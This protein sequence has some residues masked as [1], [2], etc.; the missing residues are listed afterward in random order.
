LLCLENCWPAQVRRQP[1]A[2][3]LPAFCSVSR[4]NARL[5]SINLGSRGWRRFLCSARWRTASWFQKIATA[6]KHALTIADSIQEPDPWNSRPPS[7]A[8]R[9]GFGA[10]FQGDSNRAIYFSEHV[11]AGLLY[12]MSAAAPAGQL[13]NPTSAQVESGASS[14]Q[15]QVVHLIGLPDDGSRAA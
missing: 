4:L 1:S 13:S 15:L 5:I 3:Q 9:T 11:V 7:R 6:A 14:N 10:S 2:W 8:F 12:P